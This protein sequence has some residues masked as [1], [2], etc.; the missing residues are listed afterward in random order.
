[1]TSRLIPILFLLALSTPDLLRFRLIAA[2]RQSDSP[3]NKGGSEHPKTSASIELLT[4]PQGVDLRPYLRTVFMSVK[5]T[6]NGVMPPSVDNGEKGVNSVEFHILRNGSV[7]KDSV[8]LMFGSNKPDLDKASM[9]A[10]IESSP[11]EPLP[12]NLTSD[13]LA[14]RIVFY[15]NTQPER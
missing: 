11:F 1:M 3:Q 15:Y 14:L 8:R 5:K 13:F 12:E 4:D 2:P 6:W 10:V 9:K 7:S